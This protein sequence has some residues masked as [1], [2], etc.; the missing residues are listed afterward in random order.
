DID[1]PFLVVTGNA[2]EDNAIECMK[3]GAADYLIKDRLGRLGQAIAHATRAREVRAE[4]H[5][6]EIAF[7]ESAARFR[8]LTEVAQEFVYRVRL[9]PTPRIEYVSSGIATIMGYTPEEFYADPDIG[10]KTLHPQD[11][12]VLAR[13]YR[14]DFDWRAPLIVRWIHKEGRIVWTE[15][16]ITPIFDKDGTPSAIEGVAR[17]ITAAKEAELALRESQER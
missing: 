9:Q 10:S 2:D 17:D 11:M 15:Q 16:Y 4:K 1:V 7:Q 8:R 13:V 14:L 5:Q 12:P 6:L 3:V